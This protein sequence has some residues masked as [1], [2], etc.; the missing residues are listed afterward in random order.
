M[1]ALVAASPRPASSATRSDAATKA[2]V[3]AAG[4]GNRMRPLSDAT[5]AAPEGARQAADRVASRG[6]AAGGVREVVINTACWMSRSSPR[7]ATA[8]ASASI[9]Y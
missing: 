5:P 4:R 1:D 3:L 2:I 6:A 7:S 9:A 8:R